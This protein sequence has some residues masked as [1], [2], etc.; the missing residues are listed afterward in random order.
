[1]V[2]ASLSGYNVMLLEPICETLFV[3]KGDLLQPLVGHFICI[4]KIVKSAFRET[5]FK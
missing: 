1:M 2:C 3:T 5:M 4:T